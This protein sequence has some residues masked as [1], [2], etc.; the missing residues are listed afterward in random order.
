MKQVVGLAVPP[1]IENRPVE[2]L[3]SP[4]SAEQKAGSGLP[5]IESH[6]LQN[7]PSSEPIE[8]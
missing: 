6:L 8:Q 2:L 3:A 5:V 4:E 1:A 7:L